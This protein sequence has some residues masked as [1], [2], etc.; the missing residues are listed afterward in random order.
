MIETIAWTLATTF[1]V[2]AASVAAAYAFFYN[3]TAALVITGTQYALGRATAPKPGRS[4]VND[5][6]TRGSVRQA[7][8]PQRVVYGEVELGGAIFFLDDS[9]PPYLYLGLLLSRRRVSQFVS[10]RLGDKVL[11]FDAAGNCLTA[12]YAGQ[13]W[14]SFRDGDP[15]QAIDPLL[16][17]DFPNLDS[18]FRQRGIATVVFKFKYSTTGNASTARA[19]FESLWGQ[20]SIPNPLVTV[21]GAP[22]YDPRSPLQDRD[23]ETT[24]EFRQNAALIQ[25]DWVRQPYGVNVDADTM[26]W[27]VIAE[28]ADFDD[29]LVY[30]KHQ[31]EAA[32]VAL[33]QRRHT[34]DG[35]VTLDSS[36]RDVM[37]AMLTANRGQLAETGGISYV[38][39]SPPQ[40]PIFTI[41]DAV[42]EGGFEYRD[43]K[44]TRDLV[45]RVRGR[46][47]A[48]ERNY[49]EAEGPVLDRA[50]LQALDGRVLERAIR[51]PFTLTHERMQR[52]QKQFLL[53]ER[54][55]RSL[56]VTIAIRALGRS[57]MAL[58]AGRTVRV[59]S[60]VYPQINGDYQVGEWGFADDFSAVRLSLAEYDASISRASWAP[61]TDEQEYELP[62]LEVS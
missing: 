48:E 33:H 35:V 14:A 51:L 49:Q 30:L 37:E 40:E 60:E 31:S 6:G 43:N 34:I 62:E 36:P 44:P 22:V 15:D 55:G 47:L 42:L 18:S 10:V 13:I 61:D 58:R 28:A 5:P 24:W 27:D 32:G 46:F 25:A 1:A 59:W 39:S 45:N 56:T 12:G 16:A 20:V 26:D 38:T 52:L 3:V 21:R 11:N 53:E 8:P 29:V 57:S 19:E 50:D 54:L 2:E 7:I 41:D 23:D 9:K 17:A 4:L